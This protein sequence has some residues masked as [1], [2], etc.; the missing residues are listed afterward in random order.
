MDALAFPSIVN[1]FLECGWKAWSAPDGNGNRE[2]AGELDVWRNL[3]HD[4]VHERGGNVTL[5]VY[6]QQMDLA[7]KAP[8]PKPGAVRCMTVH[9]AKGLEFRHVY[10]IGMAQ[11]VFPSFQALRKGA[12]SRELEEER[13]SC[14][15]AITRAERTLTLTRAE[16]YHGYPKPPSQF[17]A[18]MGIGAGTGR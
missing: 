18:E 1:W 10:L 2:L 17:L 9:G 13:R 3:H 15:V 4:V 16:R 12:H 11:E 7:S 6:L 8:V 14:F 5:N